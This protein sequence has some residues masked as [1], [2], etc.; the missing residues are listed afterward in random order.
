MRTQTGLRVIFP[1]VSGSVRSEVASRKELI[2]A[3]RGGDIAELVPELDRFKAV[4][5]VLELERSAV[6]SGN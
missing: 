6:S 3:G 2:E 4:D 5:G 1:A